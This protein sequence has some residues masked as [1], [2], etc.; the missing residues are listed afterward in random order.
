MESVIIFIVVLGVLIFFHELG[1]FL[2]AKLFGVGV[3]RFSLGFGPR[4]FGKKIGRTDYRVSIVPLG[5][6]VKMIGDEPNAPLDPE[7]VPVSFTHKHVAKRSLI[8][9]AGP[10]FNILLAVIIFSMVFFFAGLPSIRPIVRDVQSNSPAERS[11]I[12]QG[13][14][15]QEI[16]GRPLSSWMQIEERV[17]ESGGEPLSLT[18]ERDGKSIQTQVQP[19]QVSAQDVF[20][21]EIIYYDIG[22]SGVSQ[23]GAV[24]DRVMPN[25]P[26]GKAGLQNGDMIVAV[27]G[28]PVESW[29]TM[30]QIV[31]SSKGRPLIFK[32]KR[33]NRTFEVDIQPKEVQEK[34]LLGAKQ[35]VYRIGILGAGPTIPEQD[36]VTV[37]F[38]IFEAIREGLDRTWY[39]IAISVKFFGKMFQGQVPMESIGGPIRIAQMAQQQANEGLIQLFFFMAAVS[40]QL[41]ILNL[42][43]IPVL[44]GG[45]LLFFGIE[46]IQRR[47]V[48]TRLRET[49]QQIGIFLLI[50]LMI[51]VFY[52]DITLTWFR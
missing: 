40:V 22:I 2:V 36:R 18:I 12:Q 20:G 31:S 10:L 27:D 1:H 7:D 16:N 9:A 24:V 39:V 29:E 34:D 32:I 41:A 8:V 46:A 49:A 45:H 3:E 50:L 44:D 11:G 6:Y 28:Y 14:L 47:P 38:N 17:A 15:I 51:F 35:S 42:L 43:P 23:P 25:M 33:D 52:N 5:G 4:I 21:D 19:R 37:D 30:H 13:D 26:A 48:S